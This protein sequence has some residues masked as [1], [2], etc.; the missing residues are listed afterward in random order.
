ML[1]TDPRATGLLTLLAHLEV[2]D[3]F[4]V[5]LEKALAIQFVT[6]LLSI[7]VLGTLYTVTSKLPK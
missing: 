4:F 1:L 3:Q 6:I 7:T 5:E 2:K